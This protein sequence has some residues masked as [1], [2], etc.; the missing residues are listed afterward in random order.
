LKILA[1]GWGLQS[2]TLAA[3]SALG[4]LPRLD[5]AIHADTTHEMTATY[6]FAAQWT[7]WL[8]CRGIRVVT[9]SDKQQAAK[10]TT[11]KT[12]IPAFVLKVIDEHGGEHPSV[13]SAGDRVKG[14]LRRQCTSR[15]KIQPIRRY[16]RTELGRMGLSIRDGVVE[17]WFGI[18]LDEIQRAKDSD[19]RYISHRFPLLE[20]RF[21]RIDCV[22]W[23]KNNHLPIPKKSSCTFCPYHNLRA[24]QALKREGGPDWEAALVV[25][26][27]IRDARPPNPLYIHP[28]CLPLDQ[29]IVIPD[30]F[31]MT[32]LDMFRSNDHD[33]ECDSGHC[34]L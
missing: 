29:A 18:T 21:R 2:W 28:A 8:E 31:G 33:S 12:D 26:S 11:E 17:Q 27:A 24:W 23:L 7:P 4:E 30:D 34:F 22:S 20:R 1:L 32:Q 9:V 3:M 19:V 25:D 5:F 14:Q 16:I 13:S 6:Q 10:V 15:W